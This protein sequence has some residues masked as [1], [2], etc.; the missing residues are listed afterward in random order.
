MAAHIIFQF[1]KIC[2]VNQNS[3]EKGIENTGNASLKSKT[4]T[5]NQHF[6]L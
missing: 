1:K 2:Y 3:L 4:K 5:T 6:V